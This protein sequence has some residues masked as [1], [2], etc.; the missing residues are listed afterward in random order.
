[1]TFA[2]H[3]AREAGSLTSTTEVLDDRVGTEDVRRD[4]VSVRAIGAVIFATV[5]ESDCSCFWGFG[6]KL[7]VKRDEAWVR[8]VLCG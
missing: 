5:K 4:I 3:D 6:G 8:R 7:G 2:Q 1:L